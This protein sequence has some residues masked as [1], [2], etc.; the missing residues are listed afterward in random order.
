MKQLKLNAIIA[1]IALMTQTAFSVSPA[2]KGLLSMAF[3]SYALC[4]NYKDYLVTEKDN[5]EI[6]VIIKQRNIFNKALAQSVLDRRTDGEII[7]ARIKQTL[8]LLPNQSNIAGDQR[9]TTRKKKAFIAQIALDL[10]LLEKEEQAYFYAILKLDKQ[11]IASSLPRI[12]VYLFGDRETR[13]SIPLVVPRKEIFLEGNIINPILMKTIFAAY[14]I[15][16]S[17]ESTGKWYRYTTDDGERVK[18]LEVNFNL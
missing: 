1:F 6:R 16:L 4:P 18:A 10:S 11:I 9:S 8:E 2:L 17:Q 7:L 12:D 14:Q 5:S 13:I 15:D 3:E